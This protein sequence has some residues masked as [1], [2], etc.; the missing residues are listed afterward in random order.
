MSIHGNSHQNKNPHHLYG[1]FEGETEEVF[2]YGITHDPIEADGLPNRA[3]VQ[4]RWA[5]LAAGFLKFFA[6]I[7]MTGLP[8]RAVAERIEREHIEAY[9]QK[10]GRRPPGNLK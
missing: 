5:N 9:R 1:I 8:G 7:L 10:Y 6:K 4:L 3:K 2:K